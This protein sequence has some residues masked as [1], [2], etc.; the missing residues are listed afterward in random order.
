MIYITGLHGDEYIPTIALASQNI[1]QIIGNP[2]AISK[3]KRFLERD[4]NM[5]FGT[6]GTSYEEKIAKKLL[7]QIPKDEIII[8]FHT[9]S[10]ITDPF[11]I[12]V[13]KDMYDLALQT[14]LKHIVYMRHNIKQNHALINHRK[15]MSI[16]TGQHLS[17]SSF[18][19]TLKIIKNLQG[20]IKYPATLYEVYDTISEAGDYKN[21]KLY[22]R[23]FYPVLA[24]E[25]AYAFYGLKAK[26]IKTIKP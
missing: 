3:N 22:D 17:Y 24:G 2:K 5:S 13:D 25:K 7:K 1:P 21:F 15:G 10:S 19:S 26:K 20:G 12:I 6:K 9:T 11:A 14:G 16:E 18:L 4:L 23:K 8:D